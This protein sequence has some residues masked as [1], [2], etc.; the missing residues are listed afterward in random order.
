VGGN[1]DDGDDFFEAF[2]G[3]K[4]RMWSVGINQ[5]IDAAAMDLYL[6]YSRYSG[7]YTHC[8]FASNCGGGNTHTHSAED[9]QM[10]VAGAVIRF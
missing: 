5:A 9:L 1:V 10:V 3:S 2:R 6:F 8:D 7:D 4:M